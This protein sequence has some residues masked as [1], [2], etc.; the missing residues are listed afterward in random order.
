MTPQEFIVVNI[1]L[2]A[3]M[4]AL[5]LVRRRSSPTQ[6]HFDQNHTQKSNPSNL[7]STEAQ[8]SQ[9]SENQNVNEKLKVN[10]KYNYTGF[11]YKPR[12]NAYDD[13]K[14]LNVVFNYNGHSWD[15]YE[16]LGVPAGS[17]I[18]NIQKAYLNAIQSSQK[19]SAK[20]ITAAFEAIVEAQK[21]ESHK[22]TN[23]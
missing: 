22:K 9:L 12:K 19:D 18:E 7:S 3:L 14:S 11:D 17:S 6:L 15:A 2:G 4:A 13:A 1:V 20:F 8:N 21:N 5:F 10:Q 23:G 16:V